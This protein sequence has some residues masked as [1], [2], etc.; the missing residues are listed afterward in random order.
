[1]QVNLTHATP[2]ET[3]LSLLWVMRPDLGKMAAAAQVRSARDLPPA[4]R[5]AMRGHEIRYSP[6]P[7]IS[8]TQGKHDLNLKG[9]CY[10]R[11]L[12]APPNYTRGGALIA[13]H[14]E[15]HRD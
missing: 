10:L 7:H 1:V 4:F 5:A 14:H 12:P 15:T 13:R 6:L 9:D 11:H 8:W 2:F 3:W